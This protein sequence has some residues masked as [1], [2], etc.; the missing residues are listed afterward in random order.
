MVNGLSAK[1]NETRI[2]DGGAGSE[3]ANKGAHTLLA[4]HADSFFGINPG[5]VPSSRGWAPT[6]SCCRMPM[7][8]GS[9][10]LAPPILR[11]AGVWPRPC[12]PSTARIVT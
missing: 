5:F 9:P 7:R 12:W 2:N 8:C 4:Y 10:C 6:A 11:P 1:D 3:A